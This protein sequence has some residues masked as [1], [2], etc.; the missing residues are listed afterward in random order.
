MA[1][2]EGEHRISI[3]CEG[4]T[5]YSVKVDGVEIRDYLSGFSLI[6]KV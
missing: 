4:T 1:I 6:G 5:G 2:V 3:S